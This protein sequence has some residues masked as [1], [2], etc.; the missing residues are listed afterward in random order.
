MIESDSEGFIYPKVNSKS[1]IDCGLCT[2]VC[3]ILNKQ[4]IKNEPQ[5]FACYNKDQ[6][7]RSESSSGGLFTLIAERII[8]DGGVV[9]G[10]RLET[11]LTAVHG[12][13][14]TKEQ[15]RAFRGSKYIQS[16]IGDTYKTV[17]Q[18]L[19]QNR[20]V[21]FSGTPCQI[22][23]LKAYLLKDYDNLFCTDIICH[24]VPS[25]R[26]WH[27]YIYYQEKRLGAKVKSVSFKNKN[28]GWK[29]SSI[30]L[31][32]DNGTEYSKTLDIDLFMRAFLRD[33][34][35]R[36]S[37]YCCNFKTLQRQSDITLADFWGIQNVLPE[38][39]D[40]RGTSLLLINSTKGKAMF[41]KIKEEIVFE[42]V[43]I[44]EA[45][46][47]NTSAIKSAA[48]NPNREQFFSELDTLS[49]DK[50]VNKYCSDSISVKLN[51]KTK[52]VIVSILKK[53]GLISLAK[54][55]MKHAG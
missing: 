38:M 28:T 31:L 41:D 6:Q 49:F 39:D 14:Q 55:A 7:I 11:D 46:S 24:G 30:S 52:A 50:L 33:V 3:P 42:K 15:L 8:D 35:L 4:Q 27:K 29:R 32:F 53:T 22:A 2:K 12:Y 5:A 43:D 9:F 18:F 36:P 48:Q 20:E 19:E 44:T 23:G 40:N 25:R 37:C 51:R 21:L 34:C 17:K 26:V 47:E 45:L 54:R 13:A 16:K 10:V 1:C